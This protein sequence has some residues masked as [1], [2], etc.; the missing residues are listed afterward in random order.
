[1]I[2]NRFGGEAVSEQAVAY[3]REILEV[4]RFTALQ[5]GRLGVAN[6]RKNTT[7]LKG[8]FMSNTK[9]VIVTGATGLIGK[10]LCKQLSLEGYEI[11]VFSRHPD[12]ARNEVPGAVVAWTPSEEGEWFSA[13]DGAYGIVHLA[14]AN[15]FSKRWSDAYKKE[16]RESRILGTRGIVN[17]IAAAEQKPQVFISGSAIGYYGFRDDTTLDESGSPGQDFLARVCVEWEQEGAKA[18]EHGVRTV[19]L[20]TGI[21]LDPDEGALAQMAPMFRF[22]MGG[23]ISPGTQWFSW[24]HRDDEV[25]MIML[26]LQNE[27]IS[28]PLNATAP[29]PQTNQEFSKTLAKV[30]GTPCWLPVPKF[31]LKLLLGEVG[32]MLVEGQRV[33][34]QKAQDA[35]YQFKYPTSEEALQNLLK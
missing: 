9:R 20:R 23:P 12:K 35:G 2:P 6:P 34:P 31:G 32:D 17:A 19:L 10:A 15:V 28:G 16:I 11:V 18:E 25:G 21:V 5:S 30:L 33:V 7:T 3:L 8:K 26:A 24:V 14:G 22:Y 1:L 29:E 13:I 4:I 27:H